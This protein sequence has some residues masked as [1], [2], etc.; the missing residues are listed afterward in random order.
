M[1]NWGSYQTLVGQ[2]EEGILIVTINRPD[3]MNALNKTVLEELEHAFAQIKID[4]AV[5]GIIITGSG[6]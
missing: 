1:N 4:P 3:K 2:L 5:R 6:E